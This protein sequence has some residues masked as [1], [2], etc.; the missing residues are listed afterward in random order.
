MHATG[1]WYY[2][3]DIIILA[4]ILRKREPI[5]QLAD[6][7]INELENNNLQTAEKE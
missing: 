4:L 5:L 2:Q 7:L 3:V 1:E 6:Q